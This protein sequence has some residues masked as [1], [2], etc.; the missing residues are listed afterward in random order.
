M[1]ETLDTVIDYIIEN[2]LIKK[3]DNVGIG[4]SGG[5][6]SMALLHF[7]NS[8]AK[9]AGFN[10]V[11]VNVNH[12]IR[13]GSRKDSAFVAKYCK[14]NGIDYV[15]LNVEVLTF[16][17]QNKMGIEA[18]AR[19]KRYEAFETAI[20]KKKLTK[21]A[22]AHHSGDQAETILLHIFRGSGIAGARG[23]EVKRG[24]YIRPF[25]ET[26]KTD[27]IAYSYRMQVPHV[28]DETNDDNTIP[29]NFIRNQIIPNLQREW[30]NVEKNIIDFGKNCRVDDEYLDSLVNTESFQVT[31]TTVRVPLNL[32]AYDDSITS[33]VALRAFEKLGLRENIEK[34]HIELIVTLARTGENGSRVDLPNNLF[35]VREY[36]YLAL[37]KKVSA[38]RT[39][40]FPFKIGRTSFPE[41]GIINVT[42]TIKFR[43]AIERKMLVVDVDKLP[44]NAKWRTR[45][46]GD[47]FTKFGGG[48]KSLN[49]YL[50]DKKVPSRLRDRIPVLAVGNDIYAIAGL[51][52]SGRAKVD[53]ETIEGYVI[54]CIVEK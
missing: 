11:A 30:R 37:V 1:T 44:R 13:A 26:A 8:I 34:K 20:K 39:K 40:T 27:L 54:E 2:G 33:R 35:A 41:F 49:A 23:M 42:K 43:D 6:D 53:H 18:A 14:A 19:V 9:E 21:F 17:K 5:A 15:G 31:D 4:V 25:L 46:D 10:V 52:I 50:I 48:T 7:L 36:E 47:N 24:I 3:G 45:K 51:E 38:E 22:L 32:F 16:A 29:R 28:H 12:N